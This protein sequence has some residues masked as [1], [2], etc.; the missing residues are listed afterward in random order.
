MSEKSYI[1][2]NRRKKQV[3]L[4]ICFFYAIVLIKHFF[5]HFRSWPGPSAICCRTGADAIAFTPQTATPFIQRNFYRARP[6]VS[7]KYTEY[8]G[9]QSFPTSVSITLYCSSLR[10]S[11]LRQTWPKPPQRSPLRC[12]TGQCMQRCPF[13][14]SPA[15]NPA[16][17]CPSRCS[18]VFLSPVFGVLCSFQHI[19]V[20]FLSSVQTS[21]R[22]S[23]SAD[24]L[25]Y[26]L[27]VHSITAS[28]LSECNLVTQSDN[29]MS[30]NQFQY[31]RKRRIG[32]DLLQNFINKVC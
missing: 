29:C 9:S 19:P 14:C 30:T 3:R 17:F 8:P 1:C 12:Y 31:F 15:C 6:I 28:P 10:S 21:S 25:P 7:P 24:F 2:R 4:W 5:G 18:S 32:S 22:I 23:K 13:Y 16:V 11:F 27:L 20:L 26:C